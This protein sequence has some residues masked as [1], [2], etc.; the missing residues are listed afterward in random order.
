[1]ASFLDIVEERV[2]YFSFVE[3]MGEFNSVVLTMEKGSRRGYWIPCEDPFMAMFLV[4]RKPVQNG[5]MKYVLNTRPN[6]DEAKIQLILYLKEVFKTI[7]KELDL[8]ETAIIL[9]ENWNWKSCLKA[10]KEFKAKK[11]EINNQTEVKEESDE[12]YSRFM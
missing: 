5:F 7:G 6:E 2:N 8:K 1:M 10:V 3:V 11:E 12:D 4:F 9:E